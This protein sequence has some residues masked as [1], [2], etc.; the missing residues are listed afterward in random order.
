MTATT[1]D[2][3]PQRWDDMPFDTP[4]DNLERRRVVGEHAMLSHVTLHAGCVVPS[5]AHDNEQF[6]CV[7]SG[8]VRF[9]VGAEGGPDHREHEMATGEVLYLPANVPHSVVALEESV[10]IDVF[11]PPSEKTGVDR[12]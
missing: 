12:G 4:L 8:R 5:H 3:R 2:A 6:A 1:S 10:V 11:S 7:V 9:G